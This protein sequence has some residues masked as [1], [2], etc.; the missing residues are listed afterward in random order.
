MQQFPSLILMDHP[1]KT[2]L[3]TEGRVESGDKKQMRVQ[4][5]AKNGSQVARILFLLLLTTSAWPC[6][7]HSRNL[8]TIL[9]PGPVCGCEKFVVALAYVFCLPLPGSCLARFAYFLA[10]LF[11]VMYRARQKNSSQV[12]RIFQARPG[13]SG[14]QQQE[15]NSHNLGTVFLPGPVLSER[16]E[17]LI[18]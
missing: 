13:R 5:P 4:G 6:L 2:H 11:T 9:L 8:G 14:K 10:D 18:K 15:Q 3:T 16:T 17:Q 1:V 12:A 7:K